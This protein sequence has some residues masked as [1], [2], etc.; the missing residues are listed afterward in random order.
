MTQWVGDDPFRMDVPVIF[1]G[2]IDHV[3]VELNIRKVSQMVQ[4]RGDLVPP[5][6]FYLDGGLPV[7]GSVWV[8]ENID[9]GDSVYWEPDNRGAGYR[10][11]QDATLHCLEYLSEGVLQIN[12][13]PPMSVP[14]T[15]KRGETLAMIAARKGTTEDALKAANGIRDGKKI[16]PGDTI[17]IPP[18]LGKS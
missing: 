1:D 4:S 17:M 14:Y 13:P 8:M 9:W 18:V 15:V 7:S 5:F 12:K 11:R 16:E 3:S 2:F 10:T 6:T